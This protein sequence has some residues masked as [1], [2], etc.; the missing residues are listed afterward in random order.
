ML[1]SQG[2]QVQQGW[3]GSVLF[4]VHVPCRCRWRRHASQRA[5]GL[6]EALSLPSGTWL[7]HS[8]VGGT[9]RFPDEWVSDDF[10][11]SKERAVGTH[12]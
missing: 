1:R 10:L 2:E 9:H 7:G 8:E 12:L 6:P 3:V 4:T 11:L 5:P